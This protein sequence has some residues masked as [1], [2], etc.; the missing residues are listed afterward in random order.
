MSSHRSIRSLSSLVLS[1]HNHQIARCEAQHLFAA[2]R[3]ILF[4]FRSDQSAQL[5]KF[6]Q[7]QLGPCPPQHQIKQYT[8]IIN[9][10][11]QIKYQNS[12]AIPLGVIT[13]SPNNHHCSLILHAWPQPSPTSFWITCGSNPTIQAHP[14]SNIINR[15]YCNNLL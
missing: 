1:L 11:F 6:Y 5:Q 3:I 7:W 8:G 13:F 15:I 4:T 9:I 14:H 12:S 2:L 10:L